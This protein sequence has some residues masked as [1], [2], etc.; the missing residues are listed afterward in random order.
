MGKKVKIYFFLVFSVF[1]ISSLSLAL[2]DEDFVYYTQGKILFLKGQDEAAQIELEKVLFSA[3]YGLKAKYIMAALLGRQGKYESAHSYF[4]QIISSNMLSL[5]DRMLVDLA[6]LGKARLYYHQNQI[7]EAVA[8]YQLLPLDS[9]FATVM[10]YELG[11]AYIGYGDT[12]YEKPQLAKPIYQSAQRVF[13]Q[14]LDLNP[15]IKNDPRILLALA[16][17]SMRLGKTEE[18]FGSYQKLADYFAKIR[19]QLVEIAKNK[20]A[21]VDKVLLNKD[22]VF[23][24]DFLWLYSQPE[25]KK[26]QDEARKIQQLKE[27]ILALKEQYS[28]AKDTGESLAYLD[29]LDEQLLKIENNFHLLFAQSLNEIMKGWDKKASQLLAC[30]ENG[31]MRVALQENYVIDNYLRRIEN[32]KK[33]ELNKMKLEL[34]MS[35]GGSL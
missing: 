16:D 18:A 4:G 21:F 31:L 7:R 10:L 22:L 1:L 23:E 15:D 35:Q 6:I 5:E 9:S 33:I 12:F 3:T 30:A 28:Q 27:K 20:E 2:E 26:I 8:G 32:L 24:K 34:G 14:L 19:L 17:L 29:L 25:I 13:D 11:I